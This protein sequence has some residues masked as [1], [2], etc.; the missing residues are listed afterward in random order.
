MTT[1]AQA[2]CNGGLAMGFAEVRRHVAHQ[3]VTVN[4]KTAVAWDQIVYVGD[5]IKLGKHRTYVVR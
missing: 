1:L 3:A 5:V 4:G 2:M